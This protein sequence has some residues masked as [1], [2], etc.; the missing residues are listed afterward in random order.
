MKIRKILQVRWK[1]L[2]REAHYIGAKHV[3]QE[4]RCNAQAHQLPAKTC[5]NTQLVR[6]QEI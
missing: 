6:K 3:S 1:V 5:N 4:D 2:E